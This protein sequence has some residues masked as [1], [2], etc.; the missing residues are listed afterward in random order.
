VDINEL[1][2]TNSGLVYK[3]LRTFGLWN[4]PEAVSIAFE[5]LGTAVM[6]FDSERD[7]RL[8]TFAYCCIYNRLGDYVRDIK[9]KR[10]LEVIS[11]D[12]LME[13]GKPFLDTMT[14]GIDTETLLV[15][16][17]FKVFL[18]ETIVD[19]CSKMRGKKQQVV[20]T[21]KRGGFND[22][23]VD[24]ARQVGCSQSYASE[25]MSTF[26]G[27]LRKRLEEYRNARF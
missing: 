13:D 22:K 19:I 25:A 6:H 2:T 26:R 27:A 15:Q 9:A 11:Y 5:A 12:A 10:R 1:I 3:L 4:D 14:S 16:N 20:V 23:S 17:E 21:W 24:L 8:S 7:I 18:A